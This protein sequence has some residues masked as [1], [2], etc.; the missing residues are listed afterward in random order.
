[1]ACARIGRPLSPSTCPA[2]TGAIATGPTSASAMRPKRSVLTPPC[3]SM[4]SCARGRIPSRGSA[5]ASASCAWSSAMA[6]NGLMLPA[7]ARWCSAPGPTPQSP[8]SP[9]FA[10]AGSEELPR[11]RSRRRRRAAPADPREHSRPRLLPLTRGDA[12]LIHPT[13]ERLR[14]LGL[15]AMADAFLELHNAPDAGELGRE[16]WLGL[17]VDREASGRA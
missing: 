16:D 6:P 3:W 10:G 8:P 11:A 12:M 2:P 14:A 15:T 4:S 7:P 1:A 17:L 13:V 9:A 5:P